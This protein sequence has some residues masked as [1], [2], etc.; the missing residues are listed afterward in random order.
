[1]R[2][3][4]RCRPWSPLS[5]G[6]LPALRCWGKGFRGRSILSS[7]FGAGMNDQWVSVSRH[8]VIHEDHLLLDT[9]IYPPLRQEV[10]E[11]RSIHSANSCWGKHKSIDRRYFHGHSHTY[12]YYSPAA[13]LT[14]RSLSLSRFT[15]TSGRPNQVCFCQKEGAL[16]VSPQT[17]S[18]LMSLPWYGHGSQIWA[19]AV[20]SVHW[21]KVC[22]GNLSSHHP[23]A[24]CLY[25]L[26]VLPRSC[27]L[28]CSA[29]QCL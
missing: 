11:T 27:P 29:P 10:I 5:D 26:M 18:R 6:L 3:W 14:V 12:S 21:H 8:F 22:P 19:V 15:V 7:V 28:R 24:R 16:P 17:A 13:H 1:M 20:S 23:R 25:H 2:L 9:Q 4:A